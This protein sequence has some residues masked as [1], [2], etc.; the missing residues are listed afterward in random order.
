MRRVHNRCTA[1]RAYS[2]ECAINR[3]LSDLEMNID[4]AD[5][6]TPDSAS[7]S[8]VVT[9]AQNSSYG[10]LPFEVIQAFNQASHRSCIHSGFDTMPEVIE[11]VSLDLHTG[12]DALHGN[13]NS[14]G[15]YMVELARLMRRW[16]LKQQ[17][18]QLSQE[19]MMSLVMVF[20]I[21]ISI[22]LNT[23]LH[24]GIESSAQLATALLGCPDRRCCGRSMGQALLMISRLEI[25]LRDFSHM[26][27]HR[28][29]RQRAAV[30]SMVSTQW[31]SA[32]V[33]CVNSCEVDSMHA[34]SHCDKHSTFDSLCATKKELGHWD[35]IL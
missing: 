18:S 32:N 24:S 35:T 26:R 16:V 13:A 33:S 25:L 3:A 21:L 5:G 20:D 4:I 10:E 30:R 19:S 8:A 11:E 9:S 22:L 7:G 2:Y 34:Y 6:S 15:I 12:V 1:G 14:S 28:H 23:H 31:R 27:V 29:R 17:D